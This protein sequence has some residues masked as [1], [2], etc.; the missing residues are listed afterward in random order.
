V[1]HRRIVVPHVGLV[2]LAALAAQAGSKASSWA[3]VLSIFKQA[4]VCELSP[5]AVVASVHKEVLKEEV[6][7]GP[8]VLEAARLAQRP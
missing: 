7:P 3:F 4:K 2:R 5:A 8:K 6:E 1:A